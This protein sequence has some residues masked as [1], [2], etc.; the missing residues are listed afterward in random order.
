MVVK[1]FRGNYNFFDYKYNITGYT[2]QDYGGIA[3]YVYLIVSIILMTTLLISLRKYRS[4]L[5][6]YCSVC[7]FDSFYYSY[8]NL[9]NIFKEIQ[10]KTMEVLLSM[11][12]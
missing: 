10:V 6:R 3:Q 1:M 12:I 7:I 2:G 11:Y 4:R 8:D 9:I 5:W